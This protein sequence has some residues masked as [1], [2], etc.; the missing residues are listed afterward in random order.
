MIKIK[1]YN[2]YEKETEIM[3]EVA[4]PQVKNFNFLIISFYFIA[5]KFM[6]YKL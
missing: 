5:I 4:M 2:I 1:N 3:I 6:T